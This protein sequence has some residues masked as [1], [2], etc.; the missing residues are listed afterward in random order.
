MSR[1]ASRGGPRPGI[2]VAVLCGVAAVR[3][4]LG[5]LVYPAFNQ[6]DEV[7]HY[8]RVMR[9]AEGAPVRGVVPLRPAT[10]A[11]A[12]RY[13][14]W[15]YLN[16]PAVVVAAGEDA[17]PRSILA[18][19]S[20]RGLVARRAADFARLEN[21]ESFEPPAYYAIAGWWARVGRSLGCDAAGGLFW[22]RLLNIPLFVAAMIAARAAALACFPDRPAIAGSSLLLLAPFANEV[23]YGI[24]NDIPMAALIGW[25]WW[26]VTVDSGGGRST[27]TRR[28]LGGTLLGVAAL[29][30]GLAVPAAGALLAVPVIASITDRRRRFSSGPW[31]APATVAVVWLGYSS[32]QW[33]TPGPAVGYSDKAAWIGWTLRPPAAWPDHPLFTVAGAWSFIADLAKSFWLGPL[34]WH[35]ELTRFAWLDGIAIATGLAGLAGV[36]AGGF[37]RRMPAQ[38][39]IVAGGAAVAAGIGAMAWVSIRYDPGMGAGWVMM[40]SGRYQLAALV[41]AAVLGAA[42]LDALGRRVGTPRLGAAWCAG[43]GLLML[44]HELAMIAR[45]WPSAF[46]WFHAA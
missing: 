17:G 13:G 32:I 39:A 11:I 40:S 28:V 29:T 5:S 20:G 25:G 34:T 43:F 10:A 26:A 36:L 15:E 46:N 31:V 22:L 37:L 4:A 24:N 14:T 41:P 3:I 44:A 30:K 19:A 8:D 12:A 9:A 38:T 1:R 16:A 2:P 23:Y 7:F 42:G 18:T 45:A 21:R 33:L 27:I 35:G 6:V